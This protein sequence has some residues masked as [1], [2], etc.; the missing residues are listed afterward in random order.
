MLNDS[1]SKNSNLEGLFNSTGK[2]HF[3]SNDNKET[4]LLSDE[5]NENIPAD[6]NKDLK[7][8]SSPFECVAMDLEVLDQEKTK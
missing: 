8:D 3:T 7:A 5:N 4:N 2:S 6:D 1:L